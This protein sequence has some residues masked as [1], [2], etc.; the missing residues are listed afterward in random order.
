MKKILILLL[1][2]APAAFAADLTGRF[3]T[4]EKYE[5]PAVHAPA[6]VSRMFARSIPRAAANAIDIPAA[7]GSG[8]I[9]WTIPSR[10]APFSTRLITPAGAV[11]QPSDRGS[12]ERGLRRFTIDSSE[13]AELGLPGGAHEVVHVMDAAAATYQ[14]RVDVPNEVEGVTLVVAEPD[15]RITL[16]TWAAPLSRQPG[17]PVT[18]HAELREGDAPLTGAR[19]TARLVSPQGRRFDTI[20]LVETAD[21]VY[22][23]TLADLPGDVAGP[24]QVRFDADGATAGGT[25]FA[26]SGAGELMAERGAARLGRV[27]TEV[28]G[29]ALR[30]IASVDVAIAGT[31]RYDVVIA[32]D[33]RNALAWGEAVRTLETGPATVEI[34]IPLAHL[35]NTRVDD[36]FLD[37]RLLGLDT[38]GVAGR[39]TLDVN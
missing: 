39:V 7:G 20:T 6:Q 27:R 10:P 22:R 14:L 13:T 24:W 35:G 8:M 15:S 4:G 19:V 11:L 34:D 33:G 29:D 18:L 12:F 32:D 16:S 5:D 26:R 38:I 23:A 21:G 36:L 1:I 28:A 2:A 9:I 31:Y 17:E 25:R 30:I 3:A 37:V